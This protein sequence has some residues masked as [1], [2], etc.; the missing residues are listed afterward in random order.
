MRISGDHSFSAPVQSVWDT[1]LNPEVISQCMPG[2]QTF[3]RIGEDQYQAT[4]KIGIGPIR[5]IY[6]G[7]IHLLE[8]QPPLSYR[9]NVDGGG[10]PGNITGSG[11]M[12]LREE[13]GTVIVSYD[14]E[15]H[16]TGR[17]ASVGQRLLTPI[18]K[19]MIGQFFKCM[20]KKI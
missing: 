19:Q 16:V 18:A 8:Q 5:G 12:T 17:I 13:A 10:G 15:A 6:S 20:E 11:L 9:M 1:L 7:K 4:M 14:G 3:E 2:C